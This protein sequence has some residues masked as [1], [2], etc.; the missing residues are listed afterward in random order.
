MTHVAVQMV[1]CYCALTCSEFAD[2]FDVAHFKRVLAG[3]V[4]VVT[5]LPPR[6]LRTAKE[7]WMPMPLATPLWLIK[8]LRKPVST[9]WHMTGPPDSGR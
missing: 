2:V 3:D 7:E 4:R 6:F 5:A 9:V 1:G 8:H